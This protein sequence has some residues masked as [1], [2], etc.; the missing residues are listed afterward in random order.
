MTFRTTMLVLSVA[1]AA[2]VG[3]CE[4]KQASA[5]KTG[6]GSAQRCAHEIKP[7]KCP[8][9]TPELIERDGFCGEHGVAEALCYLCRP[10]LKAAFKAKGDWCEEHS[11]PDTQCVTCHPVLKD[12]MV[13]GSGHGTTPPPAKGG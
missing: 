12:K 1:A 7:D 11:A 6:T 3:A 4:K 2:G 9:C 10:Y 5:T 8:F 13:P